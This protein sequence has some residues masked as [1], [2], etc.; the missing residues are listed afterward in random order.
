MRPVLATGGGA[1]YLDRLVVLNP[2]LVDWA[3]KQLLGAAVAAIPIS[4]MGRGYDEDESQGTPGNNRAQNRQFT[5][6]VRE[7]EKTLG[8][9]LDKDQP[10]QLH[11]E[12][13]KQGFGYDEIVQIAIAMF[14]R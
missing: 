11:D 14:Q 8:F 9:K 3:V 4:Y 13:S 7:A 6:A 1:A 10:R 5:G 2:A 12:I